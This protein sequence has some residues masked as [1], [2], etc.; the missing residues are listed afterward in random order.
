[1]RVTACDAADYGQLSALLASIP[2][3]HP[4]TAVVHA[5]GTLHDGVLTA[6]T[7]AQ[8]REV[9][10]PKADAAWNLHLLTRD[11][12]LA[13]FVLYSS[14]VGILGNPGQANYAA[15]NTFLDALAQHRHAAGQAAVSL[16]WGHWAEAGGMAASLSRTGQARLARTGLAPMPTQEAL[17]LL[18]AALTGPDPVLVP[19]RLDTANGAAAAAPLLRGLRGT[20]TRRAPAPRT[21]ASAASPPGQAALRD[22]L[23]GQDPVQQRRLLLGLVRTTAAT[24]LGHAGPDAI[25]PDQG[26]LEGGLDS[27]GAIELRNRLVAAV[28]AELSSTAVFDHPTPE[29]LAAH[30]L[31]VL[32]PARPA[33]R[34]AGAPDVLADLDRLEAA[35]SA[36]APDDGVH[37]ELAQRLEGLLALASARQGGGPG[38]AGVSARLGA[39]SDDEI[40]DFIDNE[41]GIS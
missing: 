18:D 4:L 30:L 1:V 13:A 39:A 27:L 14:A 5:A 17:A 37:A 11:L 23:A 15:A 26:F 10:R 12:D 21:V 16:A 19:A 7:D 41:L 2:A 8:L 24:V 9:L 40:F 25:Q 28:G 38:D 33:A 32:D 20:S 22:R 6:Q 3:D 35:L 31:A 34:S 36:L 29:A